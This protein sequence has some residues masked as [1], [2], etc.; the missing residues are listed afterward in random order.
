MAD[1]LAQDETGVFADAIQAVIK[2]QFTV[3]VVTQDAKF[4]QL[5]NKLSEQAPIKEL[6]R[7]NPVQAGNPL[8]CQGTQLFQLGTAQC[9]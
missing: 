5:A 9:P 6:G 7:F 3:L 8:C 4:A 2:Q 1:F